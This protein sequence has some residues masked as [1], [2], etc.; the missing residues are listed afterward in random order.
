MID[1]MP[2]ERSA[3]CATSG[4][5]EVNLSECVQ[6]DKSFPQN[7][8]PSQKSRLAGEF[9]QEWG[10]ATWAHGDALLDSPLLLPSAIYSPGTM[11]ITL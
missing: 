8:F 4:L 9:I 11:N 10:Q 3:S 1:R 2:T 5:S 6:A 7:I